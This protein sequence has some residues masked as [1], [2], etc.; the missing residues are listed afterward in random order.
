MEAQIESKCSV[1]SIFKLIRKI[2]DHVTSG[3][4]FLTLQ[5]DY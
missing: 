2:S 3:K 5:L 1:K 4:E